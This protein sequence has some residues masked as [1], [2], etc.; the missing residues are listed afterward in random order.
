MWIHQLLYID[1]IQ[2]NTNTGQLLMPRYYSVG[3][4]QSAVFVK[5][6][7]LTEIESLEC[8]EPFIKKA[9][10]GSFKCALECHEECSDYGCKQPNDATK[11][12]TCKNAKLI[13]SRPNRDDIVM[14]VPT[15]TSVNTRYE[16][17]NEVLETQIIRIRSEPDSGGADLADYTNQYVCVN[18]HHECAG[19]CKLPNTAFDCEKTAGKRCKHFE[20]PDQ[21]DS[22]EPTQ[23]V[24]SCPTGTYVNEDVINGV[25][26]QSCLPCNA[27]CAT[28]DALAVEN[29][30]SKDGATISSEQKCFS[31]VENHLE[32]VIDVTYVLC[33]EPNT[34]PPTGCPAGFKRNGNQ[35]TK[36]WRPIGY[37]N[38]AVGALTSDCQVDNCD[39]DVN[40]NFLL[41]GSKAQFEKYQDHDGY[42]SFQLAWKV[43]AC[44]VV[45]LEWK[46]NNNPLDTAPEDTDFEVFGFRQIKCLVTDANLAN[47]KKISFANPNFFIGCP[48]YITTKYSTGSLGFT[49]LTLNTA[50][51]GTTI[52]RGSTTEKYAF[53]HLIVP[54]GIHVP[55]FVVEK[56]DVFSSEMQLSVRHFKILHF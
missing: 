16:I 50:A 37:Q 46:Q 11:C 18:C 12:Y 51:V 13:L 41:F 38:L 29:V 55:A 33:I 14:C 42:Y 35:C 40:G 44:T 20:L 27:A 34:F 36:S 21:T 5:S 45:I 17:D 25:T 52:F 31:C 39:M 7:F 24:S 32:V 2:N 54:E 43:D 1:I 49:G 3:S 22:D 8:R 53:G 28:C 15:C 19:N 4:G 23:C 48:E 30:I 6:L 56:S 26:I 9:Y 10:G 47:L